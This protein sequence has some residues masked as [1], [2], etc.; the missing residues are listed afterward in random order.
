MIGL[1]YQQQDRMPDAIEAYERAIA[2]DPRRAVVAANNLAWL[3]A[4]R[5]EQLNQALTLA[6][7]AVAQFPDDPNLRDTLGWVLY[8]QGMTSQAIEAFERSVGAA[9][10]N[11]V[12]RYHLAQAYLKAGL[13]TRARAALEAALKVRP[14]YPEARRLLE[15][16]PG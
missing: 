6:Q 13:T 12:F 2:S 14:D 9:P 10:D 5:G 4:D 7:S 8:R 11:P 1:L 16:L 15:S 3:Y